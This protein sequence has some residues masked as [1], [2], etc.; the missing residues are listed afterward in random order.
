MVAGAGALV[1]AGAGAGAR[2]RRPAG[3]AGAGTANPS[4]LVAAE[5]AFNRMVREKGQWKAFAKFAD[6]AAVMLVPQPVL[7]QGWLQGRRDPPEHLQWEPYQVWMSC[8]GT[9]G[10]TTGVWQRDNGTMGTYV[11]IWKERDKKRDYRWVFDMGEALAQVPDKP[12]F[13]AAKV[14]DCPAPRPWVA[15]VGEKASADIT[16]TAEGPPNQGRSD[17]GTLKWRYVAAQDGETVLTVSVL[18]DGENHD[19]VF[20]VSGS[21]EH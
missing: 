6:E 14:A 16:V 4:A 9:L 18:E 13:L 19:L 8:D 5:I 1:L 12:E 3:P 17:D 20:R 7:A 11:T 21:K 10:L 15:P 2:D